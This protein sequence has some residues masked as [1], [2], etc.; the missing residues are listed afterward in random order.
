MK[1]I[2]ILKRARLWT[3]LFTTLQLRLLK[4]QDVT[5]WTNDVRDN[6][7]N[8]IDQSKVNNV[9]GFLIGPRKQAGPNMG[10][11]D[12]NYKFDTC[13]YLKISSCDNR[14]N[15]LHKNSNIVVILIVRSESSQISQ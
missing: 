15:F 9:R 6:K 14:T 4:S 11:I 8:Y 2:S 12:G 7:R 3:I 1:I 13:I 10:H 5:L